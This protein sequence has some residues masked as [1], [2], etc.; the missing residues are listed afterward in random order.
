MQVNNFKRLQEEDE[1]I[2]REKHEDKVLTSLLTSL[3]AFRLVGQMMEM[4]LPKIFD[5]FVIA[6]GGKVDG[7][8][9]PPPGSIPPSQ[10]PPNEPNGKRG[11][12]DA[13]QDDISRT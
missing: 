12:G 9:P 6:V 8:T 1:R 10:G 11:P 7:S 2:Y 3:N 5:I 4:Y 13:L